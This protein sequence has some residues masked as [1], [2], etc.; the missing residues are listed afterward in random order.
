ME[1]C[2]ASPTF[3]TP[4]SNSTSNS[5]RAILKAERSPKLP[6][7]SEQESNAGRILKRI[8]TKNVLSTVPSSPWVFSHGSPPLFMEHSQQARNY[9]PDAVESFLIL[10]SVFER[11]TSA[12][13]QL[14]VECIR[15]VPA[16]H[17]PHGRSHEQIQ[18]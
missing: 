3:V 13:N 14:S 16:T 15:S 4:R 2:G 6:S 9:F 12:L 7:D 11:S 1:A 10:H 5:V 18:I 8:T 17:I